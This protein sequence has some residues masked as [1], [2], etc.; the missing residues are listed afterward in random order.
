MESLFKYKK[1][2]NKH[3]KLS[4]FIVTWIPQFVESNDFRSNAIVLSA[5]FIY[6]FVAIVLV[7]CL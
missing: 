1:F 2:E 5:I 4:N 7:Y 6:S 3:C